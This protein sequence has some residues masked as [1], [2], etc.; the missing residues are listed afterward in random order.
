MYDS[1]VKRYEGNP[2][3]K[4]EDV[5]G[6]NSIF[7]SAI[8]PFKD[9]YAGIF[10]IDD[11]TRFAT[12]RAGFSKDGVKWEISDEPIKFVQENTDIKIGFSY[13]PR[14]TCIEGRYYITW[15][16]DVNGPTIGM[17]WTEDFQTFY[18]MEDAFLPANRNGVL[19]PRKI[20]GLYTM[21]SRPSD[22][23]HTPFGNIFCS[24]SPDLKFWGR[25]RLV[26]KPEMPW[27]KTKIGAGPVPI[28]IEEGWL[29]IYHGVLTSC[30]GFVYSAGAAILD[31]ESPWN[32]LY[33]SKKYIL[34]PSMEYERIG[35]VPN[36]VFPTATILEKDKKTL[37]I[38]YGAADTY[39]CMA[40]VN[41]Y[42]LILFVKEN[43]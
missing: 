22:Y 4:P 7:N 26:M 28:E 31:K 40:T 12:L 10:R 11:R 2:I 24:Q 27:E 25:H 13:D 30:N 21:L 38:Y 36:V 29:L 17:G 9:G 15:C 32:V 8:V 34:A 33:R 3:I 23:G 35:D 5:K 14:V 39:V 6:A 37:R 19:F 20:G 18:Q 43:S 41:I 16:N 1:P 42:D